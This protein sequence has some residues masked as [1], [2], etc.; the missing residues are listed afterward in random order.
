MLPGPI[1]IRECPFCGKLMKQE[2]II[3]GNTFGS[4]LWSDGKQVAPMLPR[5]PSYLC[6]KSCNNIFMLSDAKKMA[7]TDWSDKD[8]K[9]KDIEY[10]EHPSFLE[11]IRATEVISDKKLTRTLA[12]YCFNDFYRENRENEITPETQKLHEQNIYE[13]EALLDE[14]ISEDLILKAEVNRYLGRFSR[15]EELLEGLTD[16][17]YGWIK[18]KFLAEIVKGN[19]KVF[20]LRGHGR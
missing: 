18:E 19:R 8:V 13:L 10:I 15:S 16:Q 4:V 2:T 9:Y 7:E 5:P 1:I 17:N 6:C 20:R 12:M 3:S 11:N 14:A